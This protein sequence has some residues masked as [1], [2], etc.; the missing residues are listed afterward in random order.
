MP[1]GPE[2][3]RVA[4]GLLTAAKSKELTAIRILGGRFLKKEPVGLDSLKLPSVVTSGGVKGKFIWLELE[5]EM[6]LWITLGM[7]GFWSRLK[8]QHS[9]LALVFKDGTELYFVDQRRFGTFRVGTNAELK[10]KLSSLGIDP[11]NDK[12]LSSFNMED[13]L[14]K[15]PTKTI[16]EALMDQRLFAGIGNYIK[17][18]IL[19]RAKINPMTLVKNLTSSE[20]SLLWN[21][22]RDIMHASYRQGGASIRNYQDVEAKKGEFVFEFQVY[23]QK[24]DPFGNLVERIETPDG[25]TT[26]WVPAIQS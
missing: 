12:M 19:Y 9:H 21:Y 7:S 17:C 22:C 26:H 16:V 8:I 25:R 13:R 3:R 18:E 24:T 5:N 11:L 20:I 23:A 4:E 10:K 2:C 6:T 14:K 15:V 1:E